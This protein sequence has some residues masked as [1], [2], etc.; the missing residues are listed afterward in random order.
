[1]AVRCHGSL[2]EH[3]VRAEAGR[4]WDPSFVDLI[5]LVV[6]DDLVLRVN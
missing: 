1:M 5:G 4:V 3:I 6:F 2:D